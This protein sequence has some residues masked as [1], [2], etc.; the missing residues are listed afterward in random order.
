MKAVILLGA[1]GT[2]KG[3]VAERVV[4]A[5]GYTHVSTGDMLREAVKA[6]TEVG[7]KAESYMK[8]GELV[9]DDVMI[10]VIEERMDKGAPDAAYLLDGYPRTIA[11]AELLEESLERR[12]GDILNVLFLDCPRDV[13]MSRLTG[14]RVCRDCGAPFHVRNMKPKKEGVC[15]A[16]G[17]ELYQRPDDR[18]ETIANRLEVFN[19]QTESLVARYEAQGK[20]VK[21][22]SDRPVDELV[23]DVAALLK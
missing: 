9:P 3:T 16:C 17:G 19:R 6:G 2:G 13:I 22:E 20:L 14:R 21:L 23:G 4:E 5:S 18:E 11:Q 10:A 7:R 15:D 8:A 12:G 1:P